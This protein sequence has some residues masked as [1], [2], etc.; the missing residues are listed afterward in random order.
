MK[1][2]IRVVPLLALPILLGC[3]VPSGGILEVTARVVSLQVGE[4]AEVPVTVS[5]AD[6]SADTVSVSCSNDC[7]TPTVGPDH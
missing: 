5:K 4:E 7:V 3:P 6:G 1:W 2:V